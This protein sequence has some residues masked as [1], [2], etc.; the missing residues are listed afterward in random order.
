MEKYIELALKNLKIASLNKMQKESIEVNKTQQDCVLLSPTG[1]GKTLAF[2]LPLLRFLD[3]KQNH[4]QALIITPTR[5]LAIQIESV[6]RSLGTPFKVNATYGGHS[7]RVEENNF[8]QAPAVLVGTPG[9]ICDH[10]QR[11]NLDLENVST[12]ILDEFDKSLEMGFHDQMEYILAYTKGLKKRMLVSATEM[13]EIPTFTGIKDSIEI[14]YL[15]EKSDNLTLKM[16]VSNEKDKLQSLF[17]LICQN[18]NEPTIIF[19]NHREPVERVAEF[20]ADLGIVVTFFH[21]GLEQ[22]ERERT[23]IKFRNGS[24][25]YLVTTDLAAR[26]LDIP[27]IKYIIHYHLPLTKDAFIHRNGRTARMSA[28]GTSFLLVTKDEELPKYILEQNIPVEAIKEES[29]LPKEPKWET[30]YMSGGKKDKINK[31]DIVGFLSKKGN[32]EKDDLGLIIVQDFTSYAA[33]NRKKIRQVLAAIK[34]EKIKGKKLKIGIS[35]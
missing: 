5:E 4:V 23:L 28:S 32:L 3:E 9:R 19:C 29:F 17:D 8:I 30:L 33:V 20:L 15:V 7:M 10:I 2:L 21:G 31:I 27:E 26:G 6:F 12:L 14:N 35:R 11:G 22:A 13:S 1:S 34:D 25:N 16:V 18:S 24:S